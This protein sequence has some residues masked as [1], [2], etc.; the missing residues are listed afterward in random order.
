MARGDDPDS[1]MDSFFITL[2]DQASLDGK[3]SIFGQVVDGW[4]TIEA[5]E[6]SPL[7]G[8][9]PVQPLSIERI[10]LIRKP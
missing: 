8:E 10:E 4:G 1:G 6:L 3:Y 7:A 2:E 9:A 5:I